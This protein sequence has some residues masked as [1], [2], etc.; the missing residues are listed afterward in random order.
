MKKIL[1]LFFTISLFS[2]ATSEE[3]LKNALDR[4]YGNKNTIN[5]DIRTAKALFQPEEKIITI[6]YK[7]EEKSGYT[8]DIN[9]G[10]EYS[11][12]VTLFEGYEYVIIGAGDDSSIDVDIFVYDLEGNTVALD[13]TNEATAY[14]KLPKDFVLNKSVKIDKSIAG[15]ETTIRPLETQKY[16]VKLK[17]RESNNPA[18]SV[19]FIVGTKRLK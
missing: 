14:A 19:A 5:Y 7:N 13:R 17:L 9:M 4:L 3:A 8:S 11:C 12:K 2:F 1:V 10:E 15:S 6:L 18:S 16:T